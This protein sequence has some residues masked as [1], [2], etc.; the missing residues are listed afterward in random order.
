MKIPLNWL[1]DYTLLP[2]DRGLLTRKLTLAGHLLDKV[3]GNNEETVIDLELRGNRADCY[4]V[5]GIAREVSALFKTKLNPPTLHTSLRKVP[6]LPQIQIK[7]KSPLVKRVMAVVI[8]NVKIAPS[9]SWMKKRLQAYGIPSINNIVDATNYVMVDIGEPM[10]AFDLDLIGKEIEVRLAKKGE[11][12]ITFERTSLQLTDDDLIFAKGKEPL[13]VAGA[14][15][16]KNYSILGSTQNILLEAASYERTNIRRTCRR[17]NLMTEAG[18]RHEKEL[19][20]NLVSDGIYRFLEII[21]ENNWGEI[22]TKVFDYY[23]KPPTEKSL[24]LSYDH[25]YELSGITIDKETVKEILQSLNFKI[26]KSTEKSLTVLV[27]TYRTDVNEEADLIEEVLR[28]YSYEKIVPKTLSLE[29]PPTI[30][31]PYLKQEEKLKQ[32]ALTLGLDEVISFAFVKEKY[33]KLNVALIEKTQAKPVEISNPPSPEIHQMRMTLLPN[34]LEFTQKRIYERADRSTLFEIGKVYHQI[35]KQY[36]EER[37]IGI[38]AWQKAG[39]DFVDFKGILEGLFESLNLGKLS[40]QSTEINILKSPQFKVLLSKITIGYGGSVS[41]D[42]YYFELDLKSLLGRG[43]PQQVYLWPSFPPIIEDLSL[44]VKEQTPLGDLLEEIKKVSELVSS[45]TPIDS[46]KNIR[47]FRIYYRGSQRTL[48]DPEIKEIREE[49]I[50]RL[51]NTFGASLK[52]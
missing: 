31:P 3:E 6:R 44:E 26:K 34:L 8:K 43:R 12:L 51:K 39:L 4:S 21:K 47:T 23:P 17:H 24:S 5:Y 41:D 29:I 33:Q 49:I 45:V 38:I 40:F 35:K 52:Q 22:E 37:K 19:D 20:P 18:I 15:G 11:A 14:I 25:L 10:H 30:T 27:P 32:I 48:T 36:F 50:R 16:G 46:Y 13:S 9:P 28:I 1:K 42:L 2:K 7:I